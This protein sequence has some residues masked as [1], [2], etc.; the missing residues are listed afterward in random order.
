MN[1][2]LTV[3]AEAVLM[4]H[5][6][7]DNVNLKPRWT[8]GG[9]GVEAKR[10]LREPTCGPPMAERVEHECAHAVVHRTQHVALARSVGSEQASNGEDVNRLAAPSRHGQIA[11]R[12]VPRA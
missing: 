7:E 9:V 1:D 5:S 8:R 2:A 11:W 4:T 3:N 6:V 10:A 12:G